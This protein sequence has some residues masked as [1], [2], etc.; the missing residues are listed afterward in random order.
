MLLVLSATHPFFATSS[1]VTQMITRILIWLLQ[2]TIIVL[3]VSSN[4]LLRAKVTRFFEHLLI[5]LGLKSQTLWRL[6]ERCTA[7]IL[8]LREVDLALA[9]DFRYRVLLLVLLLTLLLRWTSCHDFGS[10]HSRLM[11][12]L[13]SWLELLS[14]R[15]QLL[16]LLGN[17]LHNTS[18][19]CTDRLLQVLVLA[20]LSIVVGRVLYHLLVHERLGLL[21]L[22]CQLL[23]HFLLLLSALQLH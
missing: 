5:D 12:D 3:L 10:C 17:L 18:T 1:I 19:V 20:S 11:I 22:H 23:L 16:L 9:H 4:G 14:L 13:L 7:F 15:R 6:L 21:L 8:R 2:V